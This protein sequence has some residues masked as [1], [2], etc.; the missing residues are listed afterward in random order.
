MNPV[1]SAHPPLPSSGGSTKSICLG[2]VIAAVI[3]IAAVTLGA[4]QFFGPVG[5][6]G[7]IVSLVVGTAFTSISIGALIFT[8]CRLKQENNSLT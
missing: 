1:S 5:S 4:T 6:V 2:W 8:V 7:F 3:G